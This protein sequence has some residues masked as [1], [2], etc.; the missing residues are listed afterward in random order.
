MR[1]LLKSSPSNIPSRRDS[2]STI[3]SAE[4]FFVVK[5]VVFIGEPQ[6][7]VGRADVLQHDVELLADLFVALEPDHLGKRVRS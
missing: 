6:Q 7:V 2:R 3:A 1:L 4:A 5:V